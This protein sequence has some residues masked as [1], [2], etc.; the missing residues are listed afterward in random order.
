M[1]K[2]FIKKKYLYN[3]FRFLIWVISLISKLKIKNKCFLFN[4]NFFFNIII[5]KKII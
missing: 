3:Y 1:L 4:N 2:Y 5:F